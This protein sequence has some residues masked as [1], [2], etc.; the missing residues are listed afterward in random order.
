MAHSGVSF[1]AIYDLR[2]QIHRTVG[3]DLFDL[4]RRHVVAGDV[5]SVRFVPIENQFIRHQHQYTYAVCIHKEGWAGGDSRAEAPDHPP[6]AGLRRPLHNLAPP[7]LSQRRGGG[8]EHKPARGAPSSGFR[9][10]RG[11][12]V[13]ARGRIELWQVAAS[14]FLPRD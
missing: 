8:A 11:R 12:N 4:L 3:K 13:N 1:L 7:W 5:R 9:A 10:S 14:T 6:L 2:V